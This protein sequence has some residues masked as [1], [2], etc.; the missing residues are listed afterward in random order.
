[1]EYAPYRE[2]VKRLPAVKLPEL[3]LLLSSSLQGLLPNLSLSC[4]DPHEHKD[5]VCMSGIQ[6][7]FLAHTQ[8][9]EILC[10]LAHEK[11]FTISEKVL[12]GRK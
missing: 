11:E 12:R 9:K 7:Q 1:M 5:M 8:K 4:L 10:A 2:D 3:L 6:Q